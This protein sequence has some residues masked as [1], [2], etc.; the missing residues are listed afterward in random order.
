MTQRT[1]QYVVEIGHDDEVITPLE[2]DIV[3]RER[4]GDA[5]GGVFAVHVGRVQ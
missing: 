2:A 1:I 3:F 5:L 4:L